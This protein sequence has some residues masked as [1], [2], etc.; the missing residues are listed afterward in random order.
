MASIFSLRSTTHS[1]RNGLATETTM[2]FFRRRCNKQCSASTRHSSH[3]Y[4]SERRTFFLVFIMQTEL[5]F[6][7]S[8]IGAKF[9]TRLL[10]RDRA[11]F[12]TIVKGHC[13]GVWP[14]TTL[15]RSYQRAT[16]LKKWWSKFARQNELRCCK[17]TLWPLCHWYSVR[18][19]SRYNFFIKS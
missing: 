16:P 13:F 2:G 10:K 4:N 1:W 7:C 18:Q 11:T 8:H 5:H 17:K 6:N 9:R 12:L 3:R 15:N 14:W 19:S